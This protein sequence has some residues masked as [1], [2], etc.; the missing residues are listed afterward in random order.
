M[1]IEIP[2]LADMLYRTTWRFVFDNYIISPMIK[3]LR[4]VLYYVKCHI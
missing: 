4:R 1:G 3:C 2:T